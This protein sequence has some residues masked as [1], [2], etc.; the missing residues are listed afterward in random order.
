MSLLKNV[1]L[2]GYGFTFLDVNKI[3]NKKIEN[4]DKKKEEKIVK[5]DQI[6]NFS[7]YKLLDLWFEYD[8]DNKDY[9]ED[10]YNKYC[11]DNKDKE[12]DSQISK[13]CCLF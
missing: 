9:N 2:V 11:K 12:G 3:D 5:N 1:K 13:S 8:K 7:N 4:K 10:E 6:I